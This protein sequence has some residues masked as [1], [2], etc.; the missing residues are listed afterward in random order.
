LNEDIYLIWCERS[1]VFRFGCILFFF[2]V[3]N[4]AVSRSWFRSNGNSWMSRTDTEDS[5]AHF[6][7]KYWILQNNRGKI[8]I[9]WGFSF[10]IVGIPGV[11]VICWQEFQTIRRALWKSIYIFCSLFF[12]TVNSKSN[13]LFYSVCLVFFSYRT[14]EFKAF[15]C[16]GFQTK[17]AK[18]SWW[19]KFF[20]PCLFGWGMPYVRLQSIFTL[21]LH[22]FIRIFC[23]KQVVFEDW[24][25]SSSW[26]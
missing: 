4:I 16:A 2:R 21:K 26:R 14:N 22:L 6:S 7:K 11:I 24:F 15:V 10:S 9:S 13:K 8:M 3:F 25:K 18:F 12:L 23:I 20:F 1:E 17:R 19:S 5:C